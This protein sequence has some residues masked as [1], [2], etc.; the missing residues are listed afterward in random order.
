MSKAKKGT[1]RYMIQQMNPGVDIPSGAEMAKRL[2]EMEGEVITCITCGATGPDVENQC[3]RC[4][5]DLC[6]NEA[7]AANC[8]DCGRI[9]CLECNK[10]DPI[11]D[12][13]GSKLV[14]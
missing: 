13:D 7:C 4:G 3:E 12:E 11:C 2:R 5:K 8:F 14:S 10:E 6:T 1:A 9:Y